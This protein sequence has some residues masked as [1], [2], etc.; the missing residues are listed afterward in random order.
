MLVIPS[1]DL[2]G[3]RVA[4]LLRG[5]PKHAWFYEHFGN[6][7][8]IAKRWESE[9]AQIIHIVDLDAALG[10]GDNTRVISELIRAISVPVQV[11]GGIRSIARARQIIGLGARRIVI[12]SMAFRDPESFRALLGEMG[13]DRIVVA[14]DHLEG[15]VMIDGWREGAGISLRDAAE[16]FVNLGVSFL[17]VTSVQ[18]DGSLTGPD[19]ENL[20][21]ILDL[22]ANVIAS[23]GVRNLEDVISL[24]DLGLYGVI[25]GRALY[26][27]CLSLREAL[28]A[29]SK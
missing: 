9:G 12:G 6:P 20:S 11:G 1:V 3:G 28:K 13:S 14:L 26:E 22:G 25:V 15:V 8:A 29:A 19:I 21:K 18:R 17:L 16:R 24:R 7:M 4:R 23:G 5:D 10:R 2:M 27:G